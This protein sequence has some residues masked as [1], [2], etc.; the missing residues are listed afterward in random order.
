MEKNVFY[1][2][3]D[4]PTLFRILVFFIWK[5]FHGFKLE[6]SYLG[7]FSLTPQHC[8]CSSNDLPFSPVFQFLIGFLFTAHWVPK[9][10]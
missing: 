8:A 2:V 10:F 5:C 4:P 9:S 6:F 7:C 3:K 1:C